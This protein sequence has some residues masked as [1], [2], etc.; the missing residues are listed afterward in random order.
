MPI[1]APLREAFAER[2]LFRTR[3]CCRIMPPRACT[4]LSFSR[5]RTRLCHRE[6]RATTFWRTC[7]A[8]GNP[9]EYST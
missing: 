5:I 9:V 2:A 1:I 4:K 7:N 6:A 8:L 3:R